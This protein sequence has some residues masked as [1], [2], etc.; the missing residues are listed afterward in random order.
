MN[1]HLLVDITTALPK[2]A[3]LILA[4]KELPKGARRSVL[5][6]FFVVCI[7]A[8][9]AID[10]GA[11][12]RT[13]RDAKNETDAIAAQIKA[14]AKQQLGQTK[15]SYEGQANQLRQ[16]LTEMREAKLREENEN[17]YLHTMI[18]TMDEKLQALGEAS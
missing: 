10:T 4:A 5:I 17:N 6:C 7:A 18:N 13:A 12:N 14:A 8:G 3:G 9:V 1:A 16:Q 15:Q 11:S 2:L